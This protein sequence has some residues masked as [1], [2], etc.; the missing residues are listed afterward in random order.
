MMIRSALLVL[1]ASLAGGGAVAA[2]AQP[3]MTW[4]YSA[5]HSRQDEATLAFGV[6]ASD[7]A[8]AILRCR[9]GSGRIV[10]STFAAQARQGV[11]VRLRSGAAASRRTSHVEPDEASPSGGYLVAATVST[12]D[13]VVQA[14][15][16]GAPLSVSAGRARTE[17]PAAPKALRTAFFR[18]CG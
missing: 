13:P 2:T 7:G 11:M 9:P 8:Q 12:R 4:N 15:R 18:S 10:I 5:A 16:R 17:T 1:A 14:F 6:E 3:A